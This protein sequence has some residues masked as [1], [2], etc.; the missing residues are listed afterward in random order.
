MK[1]KNIL[2]LISTS[3]LLGGCF[4]TTS[5]SL[6]TQNLMDK[7]EINKS[8]IDGANY[9]YEMLEYCKSSNLFTYEKKV[10]TN[11]EKAEVNSFGK[12]SIFGG[13]NYWWNINFEKIDD[14]KSL[15]IIYS[16]LNSATQKERVS[17][18]KNWLLNNSKKCDKHSF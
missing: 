5:K 9:T 16:Y 7:F 4:A 11:L 10:F 17:T 8:Y 15:V 6:K 2:L 18:I 12:I 13:T 14:S 3:I 1:F